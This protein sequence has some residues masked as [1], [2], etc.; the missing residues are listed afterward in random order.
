[1]TH[2]YP[3]NRK[4]KNRRSDF[5]LII[6]DLDGTLYPVNREVDGAYPAAAYDIL[7]RKTGKSIAELE[8]EFQKKRAELGRLINGRPTT[9]LTLLYYYDVSFETY[10]E[11]VSRRLNVD[12]LIEYD[13]QVVTTVKT[14]ARHYPIFL[15][16]TN[17][18]IITE[19][20]LN[21]LQ[22]TDLFPPDRRFTLSEVAQLPFPRREKLRYIKPSPRGYR[23]I[24][25]MHNLEPKQGLMVG[26]SEVSD[27]I[28][29]RQLGLTTYHITEREDLYRLPQW[30]NI[31]P[32]G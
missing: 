21:R 2:Q 6:F 5:E 19:R 12:H 20:I 31:A 10:E 18:G 23:Q 26:D 13:P 8:P 1:M 9:T 16:T 24:L 14:V 11:E 32:E 4:Q 22:L 7:S 30:L 15:Y 25:K 29:A 28:P 27:I 17:N 3:N